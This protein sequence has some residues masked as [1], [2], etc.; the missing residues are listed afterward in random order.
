MANYSITKFGEALDKSKYKINFTSKIFNCKIKDLV[1]D[2][3]Q[4]NNWT[5]HLASGCIIKTDAGCTFTTSGQCTFNTGSYCTFDTGWN[6]TFKTGGRC[7]FK[8]GR[9]CIFRTGGGCTFTTSGQ[10]TFDTADYCT[11][12]TGYRCTFHTGAACTFRTGECCCFLIENF[13]SQK[14]K[15]YDDISVIVDILDDKRYVL[16]K[17]LTT[18]SKII[19]D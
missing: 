3:S 1:I 9:R 2:F 12:D 13:N 18:L 14:F 19:N 4:H 15:T 8:A 17:D 5:F 6:C 10:C 7:T 16:T 11:F